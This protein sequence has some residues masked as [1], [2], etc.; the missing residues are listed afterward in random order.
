[1][2][3]RNKQ[4]QAIADEFCQTYALTP[5]QISFDGEKTEPIF[6]FEALSTLALELGDFKEISVTL[7]EVNVPGA[8]VS[9]QCHLVL[10][11]GTERSYFGVAFTSETLHNGELLD[12]HTAACNLSSTR[13]LRKALRGAGFDAVRAHQA[14][15][16]SKQTFEAS[17]DGDD[18]AT[19]Q[20]KQRHAL[21]TELG[22]IKNNGADKRVY[23]D[24]MMRFFGTS[25]GN[26]LSE[27]QNE[28]F[29]TTMRSLLNANKSALAA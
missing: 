6:D 7:N 14:V 2:N 15:K 28:I 23:Q 10:A 12:S 29:I 26:N 20:R 18:D 11:D 25:N 4:Q 16:Q 3:T 17:F 8:Y 5:D 24:Q 27:K 9:S 19:R 1:M 13:A 22:W 21:A